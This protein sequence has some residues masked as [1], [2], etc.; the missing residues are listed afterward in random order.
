VTENAAVQHDDEL[1]AEAAEKK[2]GARKA[3]DDAVR[4]AYQHVVYLGR[5]EG[6]DGRAEKEFRFEQDNQSAL[7][8]GV[9]WAKLKELGKSVGL[10]EFGAKALIHNLT[11]DDYSRPLDELR[12]LF[13]NA[14]RMPLLPQGD[15]DLQRAIFEAVTAGE[16]RLVGDDGADREASTPGQIAVGLASLRLVK[17]KETEP[18]P[19]QPPE[20]PR[21]P[22]P[23]PPTAKEVQLRVSLNAN[24]DDPNRRSAIWKLL[25]ELASSVDGA[26]ATH[27][28]MSLG[29]VVPSEKVD[30]LKQRADAAGATSSETPLG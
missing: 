6:G 20:P 17:A 26:E 19:P 29:L 21:P 9:V 18:E 28:Q 30:N 10:G 13:W 22:V 14:P 15:A 4:R 24:L 2:S 27:I 16:L 25:D 8:G 12:D 11:E 1:K 23:Q 7:D 5:G 3:M